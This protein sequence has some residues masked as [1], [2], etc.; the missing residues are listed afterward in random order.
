MIRNANNNNNEYCAS[1]RLIKTW[2]IHWKYCSLDT[3]HDKSIVLPTDKHKIYFYEI[4]FPRKMGTWNI[5]YYSRSKQPPVP[6]HLRSFLRLYRF[7]KCIHLAPPVPHLKDMLLSRKVKSMV[8][9]WLYWWNWTTDL[10]VMSP[11]FLWRCM[12]ALSRYCWKTPFII[13]TEILRL[14]KQFN[15]Y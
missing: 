11:T 7:M 1:I 15:F 4:I 5:Q 9:Y 6:P 8:T 13:K 3:Y 12:S 2:D 14:F 10:S